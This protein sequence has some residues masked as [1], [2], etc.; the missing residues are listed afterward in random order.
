MTLVEE[1]LLEVDIVTD[2]MI[3]EVV[4]VD[5]MIIVVLLVIMIMIEEVTVVV[6]VIVMTVMEELID[7][8]VVAEEMIM[9]PVVIDV[10][11][12]ATKEEKIEV[13]VVTAVLQLLEM[14]LLVILTVAVVVV[15]IQEMIDMLVDKSPSLQH[16]NVN[17]GIISECFLVSAIPR[18]K[19]CF[20]TSLRRKMDKKGQHYLDDTIHTIFWSK[21][22][23]K[24]L[25]P[26]QIFTS[27]T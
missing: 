2:M 27:Q 12:A 5:E 18:I 9:V 25:S 24:L 7:M 4:M 6:D 1:V 23:C 15:N 8:K 22:D 20:T 11:V 13:T 16:T 17:D 19:D 21:K 14:M 3:E 10:V 26:C